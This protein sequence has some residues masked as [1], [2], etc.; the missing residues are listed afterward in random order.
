MLKWEWCLAEREAGEGWRNEKSWIWSMGAW[1]KNRFCEGDWRKNWPSK[2]WRLCVAELAREVMP[3]WWP[4]LLIWH[5]D[6]LKSWMFKLLLLRLMS[7]ASCRPSC[8]IMYAQFYS[9]FSGFILFVLLV[10]TNLKKK[11]WVFESAIWTWN[12]DLLIFCKHFYS[13]VLKVIIIPCNGQR[14]G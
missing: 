1:W 9:C 10:N 12:R 8:I 14:E 5:M 13:G 6:V 11:T 4:P 2:N 3:G 7:D